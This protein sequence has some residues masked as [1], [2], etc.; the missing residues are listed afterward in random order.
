METDS[1]WLCGQR[2]RERVGRCELGV[3]VGV[4]HRRA[5]VEVVRV[6]LRCEREGKQGTSIMQPVMLLAIVRFDHRTNTGCC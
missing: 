3:A 1:P 4:V 5:A 6:D 2:K